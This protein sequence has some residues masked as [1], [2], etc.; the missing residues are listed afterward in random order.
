MVPSADMPLTLH[1]KLQKEEMP[2]PKK[3]ATYYNAL[4]GFP[5]KGP[6]IKDLVICSMFSR[7]TIHFISKIWFKDAPKLRPIGISH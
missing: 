2:W 7:V 6:T 5:E 3:G 4:I 1:K